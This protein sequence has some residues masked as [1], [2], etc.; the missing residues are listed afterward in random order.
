MAPIDEEA[1]AAA[2]KKL[3]EALAN[4]DGDHSWI[5]DLPEA[6][7]LPDD[8]DETQATVIPRK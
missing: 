2:L 8:P 7:E 1:Y 4:D 3:D 5:D 6:D